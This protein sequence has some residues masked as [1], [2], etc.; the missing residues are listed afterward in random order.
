MQRLFIG[1]FIILL[2]TS[3]QEKNVDSPDFNVTSSSFTYN[4]GD[5]ASFD[6][7][8]N[9]NF[10]TF[11]S[12]EF[13]YRYEYRNRISATG[14]PLL[15]FTSALGAGSQESSLHLMVSKNFTGIVIGDTVATAVNIAAATWT[16]I[17]D[18]ATLAKNATAL[19]SGSIDLSDFASDGKPMFIA[20]KY[21][22]SSGS[23]QNKWTITGLTVTN[24]LPDSSVYTI[25]NLVASSTAIATNYAGVN[26]FSP[27]WFAF[28]TI[29]TLN[30]VIVDGS[31]M[32]IT[33]AAT[34]AA[35]TTNAEAWAIMGSLDLQKVTP[36][37]GI[38]VKSINAVV[39]SYGYTYSKAG[40]YT[41]TFVGTN[42]TAKDSKESIK[43]FTIV[44]K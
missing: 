11:Y 35:A 13:G 2:I 6:F 16:D 25:A 43:Q 10:I 19:S 9:P 26:T 34:A 28:P 21:V 14:K 22:A 29:N 42:E 36:D 17:T 7:S 41:A 44:V 4:V 1:I 32:V 24:N 27:G 39:N 15:K 5:S 12:G 37:V 18:R 40:T 8:G 30:W 3:C 20:F 38:A 31:S 23:I 33:G